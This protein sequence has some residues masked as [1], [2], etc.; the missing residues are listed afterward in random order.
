MDALFEEISLL[1]VFTEFTLLWQQVRIFREEISALW[2]TVEN[3]RA[4]MDLVETDF[5]IFNGV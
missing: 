4:L 5:C 1:L 2:K 3:R